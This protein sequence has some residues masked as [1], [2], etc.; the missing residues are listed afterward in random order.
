MPWVVLFAKTQGRQVTA[1]LDGSTGDMRLYIDGVLVTNRFTTV[2]PYVP[3]PSSQPALGIGNTPYG[4]GFS[5]I[6][7]IDEVVLY[8]RALSPL[9]VLGVVTGGPI[10]K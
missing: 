6:G 4:G 8:L 7:L 1:T 9:G 3:D 5:F 10:T 2:R